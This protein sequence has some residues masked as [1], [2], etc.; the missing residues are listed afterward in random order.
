MTVDVLLFDDNAKDIGLEPMLSGK[1][2]SIHEICKSHRV[3]TNACV[4]SLYRSLAFAKSREDEPNLA[5][6]EGHFTGVTT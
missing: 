2:A 6:N 1:C 3:G 5:R 4:I